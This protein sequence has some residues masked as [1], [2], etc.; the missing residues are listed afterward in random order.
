MGSGELGQEDEDPRGH[1]EGRPLHPSG[2]PVRQR[3]FRYFEKNE[4]DSGVDGSE[5]YKVEGRKA[6]EETV[7]APRPE[8]KMA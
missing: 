1:T 2:G 8:R 7:V 5:A 3:G 6:N 4:S